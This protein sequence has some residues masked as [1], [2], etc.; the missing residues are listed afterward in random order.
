MI[1]LEVRLLLEKNKQ[2]VHVPLIR[3]GNKKLTSPERFCQDKSD[4]ELVFIKGK[5]MV[6]S[7]FFAQVI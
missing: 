6:S 1:I 2:I 7:S 5:T 3:I 4:D